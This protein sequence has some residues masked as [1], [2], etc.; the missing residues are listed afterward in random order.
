MACRTDDARCG[1]HAGISWLGPGSGI[2]G[3]SEAQGGDGG[4]GVGDAEEVGGTR[5]QCDAADR[6]GVSL[7]EVVAGAGEGDG[8]EEEEEGGCGHGMG[9]MAEKASLTSDWAEHLF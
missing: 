5:G 9:L 6:P 7:E 4:G 2:D 3:G 8:A 1:V